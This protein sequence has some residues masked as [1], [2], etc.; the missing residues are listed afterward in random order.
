MASMWASNSKLIAVF[1]GAQK[2]KTLVRRG[3]PDAVWRMMIS[4]GQDK[5]IMQMP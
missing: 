1:M 4:V 3:L 2:P 5:Y